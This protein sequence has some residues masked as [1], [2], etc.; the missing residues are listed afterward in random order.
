VNCCR[1][2]FLQQAVPEKV[3]YISC[4]RKAGTAETNAPIEACGPGAR[5]VAHA[6]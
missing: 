4:G 3:N 1:S 5:Y 6:F 2:Q